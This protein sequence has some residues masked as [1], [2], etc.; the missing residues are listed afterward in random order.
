MDELC[1]LTTL[2]LC[3]GDTFQTE[4]ARLGEIRSI[5]PPGVH[6]MALTATATVTLRMFVMRILSMRRASVVAVSPD[7]SN[8]KY[9]V[10]PFTTI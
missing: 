3:R 7:K 2:I 6:V 9:S 8:I 5:L 4:F 1:Q 10:L